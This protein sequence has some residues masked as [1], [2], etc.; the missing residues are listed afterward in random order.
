MPPHRRGSVGLGCHEYLVPIPRRSSLLL[1]LA[2]A[3]K[4]PW[5]VLPSG[6]AWLLVLFFAT[7]RYPPTGSL[8]TSDSNLDGNFPLP[9][10]PL[11][12]RSC[13]VFEE[14]AKSI[15]NIFGARAT[16][17]LHLCLKGRSFFASQ[18]ENSTVVL[19][20][21][22]VPDVRIQYRLRCV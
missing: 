3:Q 14:L 9:R 22:H 20:V 21:Y 12:P 11:K 10:K 19:E 13:P 15:H 5:S 8:N 17:R 1:I 4:K 18:E 2:I 6:D 7:K 16:P